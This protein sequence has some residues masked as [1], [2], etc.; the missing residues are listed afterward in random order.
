VFDEAQGKTPSYEA[1]AEV[2]RQVELIAMKA[3]MDA[4][5]K[6]GNTVKDV[7]AEKCGWDVT[8]M[9][10]KGENRHI[11]VKGRHIE[12]ETFVVT[13]NEVLEALNQGDKFFLAIVRVDGQKVDGPHYI[14]SPFS[15]ELEG[16]V[17]S[18]NHSMKDFLKRAKA[19]HFA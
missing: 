17:V 3:V 9:T 12:G 15:K 7:S 16:S 6:L 11:E 14:R 2:R 5:R 1:D 10:P 4:E 18:V 19:P 8:S 13:A